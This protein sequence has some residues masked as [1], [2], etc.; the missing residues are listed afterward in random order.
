MIGLDSPAPRPRAQSRADEPALIAA[1]GG[2]SLFR[3][4]TPAQVRALVPAMY[5]TDRAVGDELLTAGTVSPGLL[6]LLSGTAEARAPSGESRVI[7]P[8]WCLDSYAS[9]HPAYSLETVTATEPSRV[10]ILRR[11]DMHLILDRT[12]ALASAILQH[13]VARLAETDAALSGDAVRGLSE[14]VFLFAED[15]TT[16]AESEARAREEM[17]AMVA[18]TLRA[19]TTIVEAI[20]PGALRHGRRVGTLAQAIARAMDCSDEDAANAFLAGL[21]HD[22]GFALSVPL[23]SNE[24]ISPRAHPK[25]GADLLLPIAPLAPLAPWVREHHEAIDGS[26]YPHRLRGKEISLGGRILAAV[27]F[28]EEHLDA[29]IAA[30]S[31]EPAYDA[32]HATRIAAG[33]TLDGDVVATLIGVL[34]SGRTE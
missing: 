6:V 14:Q 3:H 21:V 16:I 29:A 27:E 5:V 1:L 13:T 18:G 9:I 28:Y 24:P 33:R 17:R 31:S 4:L 26:G 32:R 2:V 8:G 10:A 25:R 22:A 34:G 12:P 11:Q 30:G 15:L 23:G 19:L 7:E 20:R